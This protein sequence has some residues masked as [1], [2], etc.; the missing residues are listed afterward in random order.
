M[1]GATHL[2]NSVV[3][4]SVLKSVLW[5]THVHKAVW[6]Q[7]K[8]HTRKD[9]S[10]TFL[11]CLLISI[12]KAR[13]DE[14]VEAKKYNKLNCYVRRSHDNNMRKHKKVKEKGYKMGNSFKNTIMNTEV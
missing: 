12:Q 3:L 6:V 9:L 7:N 5:E 4:C 14:G 8:G 11:N 10:V 13:V 2:Q 1:Q